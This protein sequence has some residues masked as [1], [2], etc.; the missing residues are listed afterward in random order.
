MGCAREVQRV[1]QARIVRPWGRQAAV[2]C[3]VSDSSVFCLL[4]SR[5]PFFPPFPPPPLN[6]SQCPRPFC[7]DVPRRLTGP[8]T[9]QQLPP[10]EPSLTRPTSMVTH[11]GWALSR[12]CALLFGRCTL[13]VQQLADIRAAAG[14]T[15]SFFYPPPALP[16]PQ[17]AG[18]APSSLLFG[19]RICRPVD[20]ESR[21]GWPV[22]HLVRTW[23][24]CKD[25]RA[26]Q[27]QFLL[28]QGSPA[29]FRA[30]SCPLPASV[31]QRQ[32]PL[33][34]LLR[35]TVIQLE[36]R[37]SVTRWRICALGVE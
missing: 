34:T 10:P 24:S 32:C 15:G 37:I 12:I 3:S 33:G 25:Q 7:V 29:R 26:S 21:Y 1:M 30:S 13:D 8:R 14:Q 2:P 18:A 5:L 35:N 27:A 36:V 20:L 22:H 23:M 19:H 9:T 11:L 31:I 4:L 6:P 16:P 28:L 17:L